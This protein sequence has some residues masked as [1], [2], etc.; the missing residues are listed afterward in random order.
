MKGAK[1]I[2]RSHIVV[3]KGGKVLDVHYNIT[4]KNSV[5]DA[6]AFCL[7]NKVPGVVDSQLLGQPALSV[8]SLFKLH[9]HASSCGCVVVSCCH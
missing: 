3:A 1:G 4:P 6:V 2:N 5:K 9:L 7:E 8:T